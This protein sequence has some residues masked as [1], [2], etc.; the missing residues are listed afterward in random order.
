MDFIGDVRV[1]ER[2]IGSFSR[3]V[4]MKTED[5]KRGKWAH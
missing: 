1:R 2:Y 3:R 5:S 4:A